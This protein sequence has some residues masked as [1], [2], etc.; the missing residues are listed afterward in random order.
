MMGPSIRSFEGLLPLEPMAGIGSPFW[1]AYAVLTTNNPVRFPPPP[2]PG[3]GLFPFLPGSVDQKQRLFRRLMG[4]WIDSSSF[5]SARIDI[6][7]RE[8]FFL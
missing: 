2:K 7:S 8:F 4:S 1:K 5:L 3:K 6:N